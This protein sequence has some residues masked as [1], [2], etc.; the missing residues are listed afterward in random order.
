M[1][2]RQIKRNGRGQIV[3]YEIVGVND[4]TIASDEYGKFLLQGV[5][6][7]GTIVDKYN[8]LSF[9]QEIDITIT[10]EL[11]EA[12]EV[13]NTQIVLNEIITPRDAR[14]TGIGAP[15]AGSGGSSNTGL[16]APFGVP[17][18]FIGEIRTFTR[19]D[20][21]DVDYEWTGTNWQEI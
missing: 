19:P 13:I 15:N 12:D 9:N 6:Q 14:A 8:S 17:G 5:G 21:A 1:A 11:L 7:E 2:E 4:S 10:S 20:G 3:S 16:N 18:N